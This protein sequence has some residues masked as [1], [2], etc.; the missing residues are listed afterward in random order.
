MGLHTKVIQCNNLAKSNKTTCFG[1]PLLIKGAAKS[2]KVCYHTTI[3][4]GEG[5]YIQI[6]LLICITLDIAIQASVCKDISSH[7]LK[8]EK[9]L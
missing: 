4:L 3:A 9:F 6:S 5:G 8:D 1:D 2:Y 7:Y